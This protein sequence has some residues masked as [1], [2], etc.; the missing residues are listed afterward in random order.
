MHMRLLSIMSLQDLCSTSSAHD[1]HVYEPKT[2]PSPSKHKF[3]LRLL[4]L[5]NA[6]TILVFS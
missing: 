3:E 5:D 2:S 1:T 6:T 4:A